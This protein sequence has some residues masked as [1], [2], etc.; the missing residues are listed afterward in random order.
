MVVGDLNSP[1]NSAIYRDLAAAALDA[2]GAR[3]LGWG[4]TYRRDYPMLRID[5]VFCGEGVRPVTAFTKDGKV[6]DH[7]LL[8]TDLVV[9]E[10]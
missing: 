4:W 1:P 6:S 9:G 5:Y 3:G 10:D 7:R 2:F 8:V